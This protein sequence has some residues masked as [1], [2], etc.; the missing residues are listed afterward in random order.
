MGSAA[1]RGRSREDGI[2]PVS[3]V[4]RFLDEDRVVLEILHG[5][6]APCLIDRCHY[7]FAY[8]ALVEYGG[9]LLSKKPEGKTQGRLSQD[10]SC[11][12]GKT[13]GKEGAV[14]AVFAK[15]VELVDNDLVLHG[16]H[17]KALFCEADCRRC[18]L[19]KGHGSVHFKSGE[20]PLYYTGHSH[21][22]AAKDGFSGL[23]RLLRGVHILSG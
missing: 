1:G 23:F 14:R 21:G 17:F 19:G 8:L 20:N 9:A 10:S 11:F 6:A 2:A 22:L 12:S 16:V 18:H 5:H 13:V 3:P 4:H 15:L 7:S